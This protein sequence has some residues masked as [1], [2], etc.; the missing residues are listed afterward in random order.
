MPGMSDEQK[1]ALP[2]VPAYLPQKYW[3]AYVHP[4]AV[5]FFDRQWMVNLILYGY[6]DKMRDEAIKELG[7]DFSG[8]TLQVSCCYGDMT[9]ALAEKIKEQKG[10]LHATDVL[11]V[12]TENLRRKLNP[13]LP[14]RIMNM[15]A[16]SL[17]LPEKSYD[18]VIIH[19]LLHE[20]PQEY[21]ERA[22][23]EALRVLKPGGKIVIAD[24][25]K[26]AKW[27]PLRY[28]WLPFLG[29][30][31]PFAPA[32]WNNELEDLLP[33]QMKKRGWSKKK[34]FGGL[35]QCLSTT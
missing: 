35:F 30:L 21:R 8:D 1:T 22:L 20:M 33:E 15:D 18:R 13:G 6:Y 4:R 23:E 11:P 32:L 19:F 12:Q 10:N 7:P 26:P 31:E 28:F 9:L 5:W 25:G 34:Y 17:N 14:V 16:S 2:A 3:W 24:F 27:H 29:L